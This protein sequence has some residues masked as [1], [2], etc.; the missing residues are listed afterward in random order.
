MKLPKDLELAL[1]YLL[2]VVRAGK[3]EMYV[4]SSSA[5]VDAVIKYL[6]DAKESNEEAV[7]VHT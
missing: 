4:G 5:L 3:V 1:R 6:K 7:K 2:E